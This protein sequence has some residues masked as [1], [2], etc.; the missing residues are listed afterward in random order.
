MSN[1]PD[2]IIYILEKEIKQYGI[3]FKEEETQQHYYHISYITTIS[4]ISY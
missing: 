1:A 2:Y 4:H 3:N